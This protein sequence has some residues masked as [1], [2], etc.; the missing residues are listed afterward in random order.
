[1]AA[2]SA[3]SNCAVANSSAEGTLVVSAEQDSEG[4]EE[5]EDEDVEVED[6]EEV[7]A[8]ALKSRATGMAT[9]PEGTFTTAIW[10]ELCREAAGGLDNASAA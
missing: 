1:M 5:E 3:H 2:T 6:E 4:V 9:D 8:S 10:V 7:E